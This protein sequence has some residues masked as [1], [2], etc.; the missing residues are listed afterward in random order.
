MI[1][2]YID[3]DP[4]K[5]NITVESNQLSVRPA[6]HHGSVGEGNEQQAD[7]FVSADW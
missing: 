4:I 3:V 7:Q 5:S 2:P 1:R 6:Q